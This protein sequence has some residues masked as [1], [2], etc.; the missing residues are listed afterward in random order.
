VKFTHLSGHRSRREAYWGLADFQ[1]CKLSPRNSMVAEA[2]GSATVPVAP[3]RVSRKGIAG[4]V[5]G[6]TP[7]LPFKKSVCTVVAKSL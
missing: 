7:A 4:D 6:A 3:F 5:F 1:L 2:M